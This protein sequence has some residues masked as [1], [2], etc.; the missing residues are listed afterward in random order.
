MAIHD[1]DIE[2]VR[3]SV[4]IVD[5]VQQYV[6]LRRTGRNWV[7][8]C[9]FHAEKSGSFN[10]REETGRYKCFGCQAG[11]DIFTF[12]QEIEHVD[13]VSAVE[14]L[15]GR[16]G[17]TLRYTSGGEGKDRQ[18]RK[19]L[20]AALESAVEW[21]HQQLLTAPEARPARDYLRQRGLAGDVARQFRLGWAPDE[22]DALSG[23]LRKEGF[24]DDVLRDTGLAFTNRANRLQDAFRARVLFPIFTDGGEAVAF[25][26][27]IL[28]G[29]TDP[30]KYKNSP[31]TKVYQK[32]KTL[33]G[34]NWAKNDVV[35]ADQVIVCE[36]Y[37]DVIGFHRAGVPRAVATC[38][39]A[40]T[41]EHVRVLK[42]FASKVVLAFDADAAGQGAAEK[43]YEWERKYKV[44]VS[45][46]R[47]PEGK[48]PGDLASSDP[49]ALAA[50]I[51]DAM[52]FLG[53]RV[54]RVVSQASLRSPEDRARVATRA[55][56]VI[57]EHPDVNVR[58]LYAGEVA[59]R[60]GIP[61]ADLSR[62]AEKRRVVETREDEIVP[63]V[64][65][66]PEF[67]A[68]FAA[69]AL[70]LQSWDSIA[71][72]LIED[73]FANDVARRAFL[74]LAEASESTDGTLIDNAMSLADPEVRELLERAAVAD[75]DVEPSSVAFDLIGVAVRRA[76][77]TRTRVTDAE[78]I[79]ADGEAR[80]HLED[81]GSERTAQGAG[82]VL[83]GWLVERSGVSAPHD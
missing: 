5:V 24:A 75:I 23:H 11:G 53:F 29:S 35:K 18:R 36:G 15:A 37:T 44:E 38:G 71:P 80:R 7:G 43:F 65:A 12:V 59:A 32:S 57:N 72:W 73:L 47:F 70:L 33:Y 1:E 4:S 21:Y 66:V 17:M 83:L 69:V 49:D 26:G 9:P 76:L 60:V 82:T 6:T 62:Q 25:G 8:L 48:D 2:R 54:N 46:A 27:R 30:A 64:A 67:T 34:L 39:T 31:E 41:E 63:A 52:P 3:S 58:K 10:V 68:E 40:F 22:W 42:R 45:V 78:E 28:P 20:V 19:Q 61:V 16:A 50:A 79:R 55:L 56:E 14:K 81:L 74:A 51:D 13:F 77:A